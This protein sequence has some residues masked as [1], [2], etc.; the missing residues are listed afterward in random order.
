[1][2]DENRLLFSNISVNPNDYVKFNKEL[3]EIT[4]PFYFTVNYYTHADP[5]TID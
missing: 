5:E 2:S 4:I 1:M 3:E